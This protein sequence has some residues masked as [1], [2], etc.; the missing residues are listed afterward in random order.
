MVM[1]LLMMMLL[2]MVMM[3]RMTYDDC[4]YHHDD[5]PCLLQADLNPDIPFGIQMRLF[6]PFPKPCKL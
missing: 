6:K 3:L 4:H 5:L 1:M 2:L